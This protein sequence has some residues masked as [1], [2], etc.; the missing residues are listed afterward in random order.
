MKKVALFAFNGDLTCFA[1]VL[2]NAL[3]MKSQG[4]DVTII[5]EGAST[6]L[7]PELAKEGNPMWNLYNEVKK[8]G[9]I[10]A[11]CKACSA[12]M[13]NAR[14]RRSGGAAHLGRDERPPKYGVIYRARLRH[15]HFLESRR[16]IP[17]RAGFSRIEAGL[18][19]VALGS[20]RSR[21]LHN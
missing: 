4:F 20:S 10:S 17:C 12:K 7:I 5:I 21:L 1:H 8:Q 9:L 6:K 3:D 16:P 15:H 18:F 13:K 14:G 11:V 19:G 2:L